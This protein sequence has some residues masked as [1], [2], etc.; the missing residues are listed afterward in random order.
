MTAPSNSIENVRHVPYTSALSDRLCTVDLG[1]G[2]EGGGSGEQAWNGEGRGVA[3]LCQEGKEQG[4]QG[5]ARPGPMLAPEVGEHGCGKRCRLL[6]G[7]CMLVNLF[8]CTFP[9]MN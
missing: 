8:S 7:N 3:R 6:R 2:S 5:L 4:G 1:T 9:R